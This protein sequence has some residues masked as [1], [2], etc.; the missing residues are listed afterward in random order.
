MLSTAHITLDVCCHLPGMEDRH[1]RLWEWACA[2]GWAAENTGFS[3]ATVTGQKWISNSSRGHE[4][5]KQSSCWNAGEKSI[6]IRSSRCLVQSKPRARTAAS[7]HTAYTLHTSRWCPSLV[8]LTCPTLEDLLKN[9]ANSKEEQ[10]GKTDKDTY[11][12][13]LFQPCL[14]VCVLKCLSYLSCEIE[15]EGTG[16]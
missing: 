14:K 16:Q 15:L 13:I 3:T 12:K 1:L 8:I 11:L 6:S 5:I 7:S 2:P 10:K 4:S 9:K